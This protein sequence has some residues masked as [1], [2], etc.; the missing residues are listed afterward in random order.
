MGTLDSF[1]TSQTILV[2]ILS[3]IFNI[4]TCIC[5]SNLNQAF[6]KKIIKGKNPKNFFMIMKENYFSSGML[7]KMLERKKGYHISDLVWN[8][9][10]LV[11]VGNDYFHL[12]K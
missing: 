2:V 12:G 1:S 9:L 6:K 10:V 8:F 5:L 7:E 3:L 11:P 4:E